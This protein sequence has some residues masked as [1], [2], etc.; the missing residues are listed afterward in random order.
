MLRMTIFQQNLKDS[1]LC[2]FAFKNPV[3]DFSSEGADEWAILKN[4]KFWRFYWLNG[5]ISKLLCAGFW[6]GGQIFYLQRLFFILHKNMPSVF[7]CPTP[8]CALLKIPFKY[9]ISGGISAQNFLGLQWVSNMIFRHISM[10]LF[11][12]ICI[13]QNGPKE[14]MP[15]KIWL[16]LPKRTRRFH[17]MIRSFRSWSANCQEHV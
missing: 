11:T 17:Q 13:Q 7:S 3:K 14:K 12:P 8:L 15:F 5:T 16:I 10:K 6:K 4:W 2:V 9:T 1:Y